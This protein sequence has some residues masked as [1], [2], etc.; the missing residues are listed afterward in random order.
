MADSSAFLPGDD[1]MALPI[2][3]R[4]FLIEKLVPIGGLVNLYGK[5]KAGKS[6]LALQ[7]ASAVSCGDPAFLGLKVTPGK[8]AYLQLDT[9]R[10]LWI[11]RI[12]AMHGAGVDMSHIHFCDRQVPGVPYPFNI[13]EHQGWLED[14]LA[15]IQPDLLFVDVIREIFNGDE[16]DSSVMKL[17]IN[18]VVASAPESAVVFLSHRKKETADPKHSK[19]DDLMQDARGSGY[20]AGRMD[21]VLCATPEG[22]AY[23]GRAEPIGVIEAEQSNALAGGWM[24]SPYTHWFEE[25]VRLSVGMPDAQRIPVILALM[26]E[27]GIV[28]SP[29]LIRERLIAKAHPRPR[30]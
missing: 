9:P 29:A 18:S 22:I 15:A 16:N 11:E 25:G 21:M 20:V 14:Q 26:Q 23:Q 7:M 28:T 6:F 12:R 2:P 10:S 30:P 8:V 1:Y 5:P 17:V 19:P 4:P 27:N 3:E 24:R 13:L